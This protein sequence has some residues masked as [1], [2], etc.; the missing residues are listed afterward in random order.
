MVP[1]DPRAVAGLAFIVLISI[2]LAG[3]YSAL[4]PTQLEIVVKNYDATSHEVRMVLEKDG[5]TVNS[6]KLMVDAGRTRTVQYPVDIGAFRLTASMQGAANAS[7]DFEIPFRF[8]DKAHSET[9]T[10][11]STGIF[12]GNIY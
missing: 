1:M 2:L 4:M 10:V 9:F 5:R 12:K 6:W 11:T 3:S 7:S 8:L